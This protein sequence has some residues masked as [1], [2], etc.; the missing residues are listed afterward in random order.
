MKP[1]QKQRVR[2]V[3]P[4]RFNGEQSGQGLQIA[5]TLDIAATGVRLGAVRTALAPG[6]QVTLQFRLRKAAYRVVWS[7]QLSP[8]GEYQ[9]GLC[10]MNPDRDLW[11]LP[12]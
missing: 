1:R 11:D 10:S 7:K 9:A 3:L 4:V 5:H 2:A 8:Q 12:R 6:S